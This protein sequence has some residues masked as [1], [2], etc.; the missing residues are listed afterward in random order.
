MTMRRKANGMDRGRYGRETDF[1]LG[2][3]VGYLVRDANRAFQRLLEKRVAP[4]GVTRGQW[5]FLR[6][7]WV[8]DG[9]SQ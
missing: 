8:E 3:S 5:Y 2:G 6:A 7:L 1:S 4:H 9:L